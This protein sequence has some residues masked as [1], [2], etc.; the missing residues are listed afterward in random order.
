[1]SIIVVVVVYLKHWDTPALVGAEGE[2]EAGHLKVLIRLNVEEHLLSLGICQ[3]I[4]N[5]LLLGIG[6]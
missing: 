3:Q 5:L 2:A 6:D 1:M 4:E